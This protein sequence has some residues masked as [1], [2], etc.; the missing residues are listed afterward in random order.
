VRSI[1]PTTKIDSVYVVPAPQ[2]VDF[3]TID[4]QWEY[5]IN[6]GKVSLLP[7]ING[8]P[9]SAGEF[10]ASPNKN[11][12][13]NTGNTFYFNPQVADSNNSNNNVLTYTLGY[14][15]NECNVK[16]SHNIKVDGRPFVTIT[17]SANVCAG[18]T[19][20][21]IKAVRSNATTLIW[22]SGGSNQ[23]FK[24]LN[25]DSTDVLYQPTQQQLLAGVSRLRPLL[26]ITEIV[27]RILQLPLLISIRFL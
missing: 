16:V 25:A 19:S 1:C 9:T 6:H 4:K 24:P 2:N 8:K 12:V 18:Q 5:C 13:Y 20:F 26:Q 14:N 27:L 23:G 10:S 3:T 22:S 15:R 11:E 7:T 21:E 17:T